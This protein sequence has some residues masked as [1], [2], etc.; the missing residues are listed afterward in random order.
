MRVPRNPMAEVLWQSVRQRHGKIPRLPR[1]LPPLQGERTYQRFLRERVK[2]TGEA[3]QKIITHMYHNMLHEV[4]HRDSLDDQVNSLADQLQTEWI[5]NFR[6]S[7]VKRFIENTGKWVAGWNAQ[8]HNKVFQRI[9]PIDMFTHE[10]WLEKEVS[11]F[12]T[13]NVSLIKNLGDDYLN[14]IESIVVRGVREGT[15]LSDISDLIQDRTKVAESRAN[16]IGRDQVGKLNGQITQMRQE[17][18]GIEQFIWRTANDERVRDSHER[19]EGEVCRWDD[20]PSVDGENV[21][22]GEPINCRCYGEPVLERENGSSP[23]DQ[24]QE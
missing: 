22:P 18:L 8:E 9:A 10:P 16:L 4:G 6:T 7:D 20:P 14:K 21:I 23:Q 12:V 3:I 15:L 5:Q 13:E 1:M 17:S 11:H 2:K 19:K 24:D